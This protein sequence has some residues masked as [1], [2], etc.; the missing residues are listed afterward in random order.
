MIVV[1]ADCTVLRCGRH[2]MG[3]GFRVLTV[4]EKK[5][6]GFFGTGEIGKGK[7]EEDIDRRQ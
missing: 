2:E 4:N 3:Q 6:N 7:L 1:Q 5:G